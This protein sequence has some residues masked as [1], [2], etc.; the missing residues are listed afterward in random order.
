[1]STHQ[2]IVSPAGGW[3]CHVHVF[4]AA[5]PVQGGHYRPVQHDLADI[6]ALA[7]AHGV[8]HL[9]LVQPSVYG[10][11]NTVLLQALAHQPERHRGVVVIDRG[12]TDAELDRMHAMGVR[13]V[14]FNLVSPVGNGHEGLEALAPRLRERGW[15]VQ[16][17]AKAE[18]LATIAALHE[19]TGLTAV[20][21]HL[22]GMGTAVASSDPAW[23]AL[24]ALAAQGAW[25]KLSGWYR[26]QASAPYDAL[27]AHI[28]RM[29]AEMKERLVWG[30]DW[31]HTA[32]SADALPPYA[33]VW[34]PVVDALGLTRAAQ[35]RAAGA[36][37]YT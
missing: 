1:M 32:F 25:V 17:Y 28:Q 31:P 3:D 12:I 6:E 22:A 34:R 13:G 26:L 8:H 10:T 2:N 14:R 15:H 20:L 29:A 4:D 21:D 24:R 27:G 18:Q 30:S 37:L 5:H 23:A 16:W 7:Q 35:I 36:A 33:S 11:D 9:V 19:G